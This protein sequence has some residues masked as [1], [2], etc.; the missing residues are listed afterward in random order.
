MTAA[1]WRSTGY[2]LARRFD[3]IQHGRNAVRPRNRRGEATVNTNLDLNR[4]AG[5]RPYR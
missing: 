4:R 1:T 5:L 3:R 2:G